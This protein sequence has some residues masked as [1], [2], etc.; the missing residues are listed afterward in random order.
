MLEETKTYLQNIYQDVL[1]WLLCAPDVL[2]QERVVNTLRVRL[3]Q[4]V[5]VCLVPLL[6]CHKHLVFICTDYL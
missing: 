2:Q 3:V 6:D 4:V 1:F 5:R